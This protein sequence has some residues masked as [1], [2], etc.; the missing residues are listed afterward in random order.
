[1][2]PLNGLHKVN[3]DLYERE[4]AKFAGREPVLDYVIPGLG[5]AWADTVNLPALDPRLLIAE[6]CKLGVPVSRLLE[7]SLLCIPMERLERLTAV[8]YVS[9]SHWIN[10]SP[11]EGGVP[12]TP[13]DDK[14]SPF[15]ATYY[16]E[17]REVPPLH[18]EY[19]L[20]QKDRGALAL[21]FV[22]VPHVLVASPIDISG[23]ELVDL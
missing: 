2:Y 4:R 21:G 3:P 18:R 8:N 7:R 23:L 6:R 13:P 20:R 15:D 10:S 9:A 1:M 16:K 22:F 5:A 17:I 19:L 11:G 14:F 12:L